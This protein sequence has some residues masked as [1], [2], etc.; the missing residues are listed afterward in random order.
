VRSGS[1]SGGGHGVLSG[2]WGNLN[3]NREYVIYCR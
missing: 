1:G 3:E 2:F